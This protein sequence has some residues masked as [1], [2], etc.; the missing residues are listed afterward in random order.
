MQDRDNDTGKIGGPMTTMHLSNSWNKHLIRQMI[1][2]GHKPRK[3]NSKHN[4]Y[5]KASS[6]MTICSVTR[7]I[8][9]LLVLVIFIIESSVLCEEC[10]ADIDFTYP[11]ALNKNASSDTQYD[12]DTEP[13]MAADGR[14]NWIA[15]WRS[16][17]SLGGIIGDDF[18]IFVARSTDNG[19]TWTPPQVLNSDAT[20]DDAWLRCGLQLG[21]G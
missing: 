1:R 17:N 16:N 14:G 19:T 18:D 9:L 5:L 4:L 11:M 2:F 13:Q 15:V 21:N 12:N 3:I 7:S 20:S 8:L 6:G 10:I